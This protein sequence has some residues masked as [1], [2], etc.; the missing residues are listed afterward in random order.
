VAHELATRPGFEV[1][2]YDRRRELPEQPGAIWGG[3]ARSFDNP[4]TGVGGRFDLPGEHG[5][6]FFPGFYKHV[7]DTMRRIPTDVEGRT[8]HDNLVPTTEVLLTQPGRLPIR[9]PARFPE[10][11]AEFGEAVRDFRNRDRLGVPSEETSYFLGKL[12]DIFTSCSA[13]RFTTY[14]Y[15]SWWTYIGAATRS[16]QYQR[17]LGVGLTRSLVAAKAELSNARTIGTMLEQ[18]LKYTL[19]PRSATDLVLNGP[20]THVWLDYWV[21]FL[22]SK[23]VQ[24]IQGA[25]ATAISFDGTRVTGVTIHQHDQGAEEVRADYYVFAL[26]VE[27]IRKLI[28]TPMKE[29]APALDTLDDLQI[30]WMNGIVFYLNRDVR[31]GHGHV[32]L[33]ESAWA[34]TCISQPQFWTPQ[35]VAQFGDGTVR[36]ILSVDVS[37]WTA[38]GTFTTNKPA[39]DCSAAEIAAEVWAQV[40]QHLQLNDPQAPTPPGTELPLTDADLVAPIDSPPGRTWYLDRD[41]QVERSAAPGRVAVAA[42]AGAGAQPLTTVSSD[43]ALALDRNAEP[44]MI[45]TRGSYAWRPDADVGLPNMFIAGDYVRTYTDLA[46]MEGAN[47]SGRRAVNA[48]LQAAGSSA[49][50]CK[51]WPLQGLLPLALFRAV[52]WVLFHLGIRQIPYSKYPRGV[53]WIFLG[54]MLVLQIW[55]GVRDLLGMRHERPAVP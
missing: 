14:E 17:M 12:L 26:P 48:L 32:L 41:I 11:W 28:T 3:K 35:A 25:K 10:S 20:T 39:D 54:V 9:I 1:T 5:F 52:D 38:P 34:L 4:E 45:N 46:T 2:V 36:G 22:Q 37:N 7:T 6:R 44:L 21:K 29:A 13:R 51:L 19:E 24:L 42:T 18:V 27:V 30:E 43:S 8:V 23:Q 31:I 49:E 16:Q 50:R 47:E 53:R 40:K 55:V 33:T 15:Y